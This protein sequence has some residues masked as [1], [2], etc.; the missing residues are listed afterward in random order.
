MLYE[1][2]LN[3]ITLNCLRTINAI[4][5]LNISVENAQIDTKI[6]DKIPEK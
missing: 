1:I 6:T 2:Y 4:H 5:P 3:I